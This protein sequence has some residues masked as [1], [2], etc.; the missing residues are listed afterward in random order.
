MRNTKPCRNTIVLETSKENKR[1]QKQ[2]RKPT[3]LDALSAC[4]LDE[5]LPER[6]DRSITSL[7]KQTCNV[8]QQT[9]KAQLSRQEQCSNIDNAT[10][11]KKPSKKGKRRCV[12]PDERQKRKSATPTENAKRRQPMS[13]ALP[14]VAET[15]RAVWS[16][17]WKRSE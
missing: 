12:S 7:N 1:L 17:N 4:I 6:H 5:P 14:L 10:P 3:T 8:A 15:S 11:T 16:V 9:V 13:E 2:N